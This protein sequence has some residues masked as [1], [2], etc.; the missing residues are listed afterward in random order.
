MLTPGIKGLIEILKLFRTPFQLP[1]FKMSRSNSFVNLDI[2]LSKVIE[3]KDNKKHWRKRIQM[4]W[5]FSYNM[6]SERKFINLIKYPF[7]ALSAPWYFCLII[8]YGG[9]GHIASSWRKSWKENAFD[10]K[11]GTVILCNVTKKKVEK[12]C[13]YRDDGVTNYVNC[14]QKL[15]KKWLEY[16]FL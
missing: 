4:N 11:Y 14:L 16:F 15:C 2:L 12:N 3:I 10:M 8:P 6:E 13:S 5:V 9:G 1:I 7:L